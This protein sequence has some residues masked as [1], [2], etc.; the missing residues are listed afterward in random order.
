M[1]AWYLG[2]IS[3]VLAGAIEYPL[4]WLLLLIV[5]IAA[6]VYFSVRGETRGM[7]LPSRPDPAFVVAEWY[8]TASDASTPRRL[9]FTLAD[10]LHALYEV[11]WNEFNLFLVYVRPRHA[12]GN[13]L[14][15][16]L[17]FEG[18][19][20]PYT[21]FRSPL[22]KIMEGVLPYEVFEK[23]KPRQEKFEG[24]LEQALAI[25]ARM[26][27]AGLHPQGDDEE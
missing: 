2:V 12:Q 13:R 11:H 1:A 9:P 10:L 21:N 14:I 22:F 17:V 7:D 23:M 3:W 18:I 25:A 6:V 20:P 24:E 27:E 5:G 15:W 8:R 4:P 26:R 16:S 19:C